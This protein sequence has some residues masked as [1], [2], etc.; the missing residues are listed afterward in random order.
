MPQLPASQSPAT[1]PNEATVAAVADILSDLGI[2]DD[3]DR[4][5]RLADYVEL[6]L[7]WN[8]TY[9][10]TAVR[11][12][13]EAVSHHLADCLAAWPPLRGRLGERGGRV[14]D[15]GSGG[16]LPGAVFAIVDPSLD[17]TC[18]DAVGK[19]S[20]FVR[21]VAGRLGLPR[22]HAVHGRVEALRDRPGFDV[23]T[24]RAFASLPS[25][26]ALSRGLVAPGGAWLAMK[27]RSPEGEIAELPDDIE[28]FHVEPITV[29]G[30]RAKRCL[31]W[32]RPKET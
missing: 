10:L 26:V 6:L 3:G 32:M 7:R 28:V 17:V 14:L 2:G 9:N 19:K 13:G 21:H 29:P 20:A 24:S 1:A 30:L 11:E 5:R 22:L 27:G 8:D 15:V 31:V 12:P 16:G 18:I 4:A 25:F 23:I